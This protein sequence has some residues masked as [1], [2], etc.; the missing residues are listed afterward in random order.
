M[1]QKPSAYLNANAAEQ[2]K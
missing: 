2:D 1:N